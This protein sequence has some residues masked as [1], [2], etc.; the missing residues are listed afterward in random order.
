MRGRAYV[1]VKW[2]RSHNH[3]N[4]YFVTFFMNGDWRD[5]DSFATVDDF[6]NLVAVTL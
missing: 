1:A 6:G 2:H 3:P 4:L 5:T